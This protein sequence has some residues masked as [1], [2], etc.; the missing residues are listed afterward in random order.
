MPSTMSAT[1]VGVFKERLEADRAIDDLLTAGFRNDQI[2]VLSRDAKG[3]TVDKNS[4][5]KETHMS[6]GA[7][8]GA[9]AGAGV[10]GLIGL[11][12][13][14]GVVPVLGP[15]IAAGTLATI[16]TNAAGGAAVAG[17][18]GA[19]IGWGIPEE[20]AK[21]Y[22]GELKAGRI[23]VT[24]HAGD[25]KQAALTILRSHRGYGH[26]SEVMAGTRTM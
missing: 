17:L 26:E 4:A 23:V 2:G 9:V 21:Y 24:V 7:V 10:G 8:T 5:E 14:A 1:V 18:S 20:H 3:K 12:V 22:D 25:R 19:L 15:A 16:L 13:L 11:G 6:D